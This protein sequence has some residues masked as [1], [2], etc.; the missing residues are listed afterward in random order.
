[1]AGLEGFRN[2]CYSIITSMTNLLMEVTRKIAELPAERLG[3]VAHVSLLFSAGCARTCGHGLDLREVHDSVG[4]SIWSAPQGCTPYLV[5]CGRPPALHAPDLLL[6][7][8]KLRDERL[9]RG[10]IGPGRPISGLIDDDG[11]QFLHTVAS[12]RG[13]HPELGQ[14]YERSAL[15]NCVR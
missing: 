8:L 2:P 1:M 11:N 12:L 6:Q 10:R 9:Q 3:D 14:V 13:H 5:M 4:P 7:C 15:I